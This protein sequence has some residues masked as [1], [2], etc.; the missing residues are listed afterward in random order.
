MCYSSQIAAAYQQYLKLTGAEI[1]LDQFREMYGFRHANSSI[2]IP[3]AVDR[4]FNEPKNADESSIKEL[5][6]QHRAAAIA[7]LEGEVFV[8]RKRLADAERKLQTKPTKAAGES[9]RIAGDKIEAALARLSRLK[10]TQPHPSDTRIFPMHFAPIVVQDGERRVVR[11]RATTAGRQGSP[12][13][14]I[15][16]FRVCTTRVGTTWRS[17]GV[18]SSGTAMP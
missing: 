7:K 10:A 8:Q 17:S 12:P 9:R 14:L 3:R 16:S 13:A 11:S 5:I 18:A 6:D 2:R 4:W 1:D 15:G